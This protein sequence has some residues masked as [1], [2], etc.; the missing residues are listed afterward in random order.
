MKLQ[1]LGDARDSFKWHYHDHLVKG[2]DARHLDIIPMLL[3]N[4]DTGQ[5]NIHARTYQST[6]EIQSFCEH[7]RKNQYLDSLRKLPEFTGSKYRVRLHKPYQYYNF[8]GSS[9]DRVGNIHRVTPSG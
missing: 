6:P 5:G 3:P 2:I 1:Y 4:D 7:L 9:P 8:I